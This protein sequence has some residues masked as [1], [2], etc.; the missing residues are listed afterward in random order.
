MRDL[1]IGSIAVVLSPDHPKRTL[2]ED[3]P[4]SPEFRIEINQWML[5]FFGTYNL[6]A[7][8]QTIL[9]E[10]DGKVFMN[11]RTYAAL[12]LEMDRQKSPTPSHHA[13]VNCGHHDHANNHHRQE[14]LLY[15]QA[16]Q[17]P[18]RN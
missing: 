13:A 18:A 10:N 11:P 6:L 9:M 14:V 1:Y 5:G 8:G 7:D 3:V 2:A 16:L 12:K 17:L 15:L 4:V